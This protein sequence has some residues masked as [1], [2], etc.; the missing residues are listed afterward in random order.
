MSIYRSTRKDKVT[1]GRAAVGGGGGGGPA[2]GGGGG[3]GAGMPVS[4]R[5]LWKKE[6]EEDK[7]SEVPQGP[8][9]AAAT[10]R[11]VT[12]DDPPPPSPHPRPCFPE[13][14]E[15]RSAKTGNR[16]PLH[17]LRRNLTQAAP[18]PST[19]PHHFYLFYPQCLVAEP[20][21]GNNE[22]CCLR[23]NGPL[24][25]QCVCDDRPPAQMENT[26]RKVQRK[27]HWCFVQVSLNLQCRYIQDVF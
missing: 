2:G 20:W 15:P 14:E 10:V 16:K 25:P 22:E 6:K 1:C 7:H 17:P 4:L 23:S 13:Q 3:G 9:Q 21:D 5:Y 26:R 12:F 24:T 27:A 8:L 19:P 11:R 18:P